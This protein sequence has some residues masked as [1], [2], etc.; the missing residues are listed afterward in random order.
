MEFNQQPS[1]IVGANSPLIY[2]FY[3][4]GY[5]S[6]GFYYKCDIYVWSGTS[7]AVPATPQATIERVP[8]T[9]ASGRA[10]IDAHKIVNNI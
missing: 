9:Y 6:T 4:A 8:D 3:D 5:A 2:Q 10:M 7:G 1:G